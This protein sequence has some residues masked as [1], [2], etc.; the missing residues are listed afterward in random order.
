MPVPAVEVTAPVSNGE[1]RVLAHVTLAAVAI[2]AAFHA[3]AHP[4]SAAFTS[5]GWGRGGAW[6]GSTKDYM[7]F[8]ADG[9]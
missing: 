7:H 3:S 2:F 9:H 5:A 1:M 8:S 4:L 6:T